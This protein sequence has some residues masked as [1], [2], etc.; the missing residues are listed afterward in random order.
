MNYPKPEKQPADQARKM[1]AN[2]V[3]WIHGFKP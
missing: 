1:V 2:P 3:V